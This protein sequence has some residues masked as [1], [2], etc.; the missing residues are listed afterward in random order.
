[1]RTHVR[2]KILRPVSI[3]SRRSFYASRIFLKSFWKES[4]NFDGLEIDR[5]TQK[6]LQVWR[7][8]KYLCRS[9]SRAWKMLAL[10]SPDKSSRLN[11]E[12]IKETESN[13]TRATDRTVSRSRCQERPTSIRPA[14][15]RSL[16]Q[17]FTQRHARNCIILHTPPSP[18]CRILSIHSPIIS[19]NVPSPNFPTLPLYYNKQNLATI[20]R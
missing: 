10:F 14:V 4:V 19:L 8:R 2:S 3:E 13:L 15:H 18:E 1:M 17:R 9:L 20:F 12:R 16:D 11:R 5:A 7:R 6:R